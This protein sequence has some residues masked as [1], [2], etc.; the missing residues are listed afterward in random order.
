MVSTKTTAKA[1]GSTDSR[2][3]ASAPSTSRLSNAIMGGRSPSNDER[4][5]TNMRASESHGTLAV[6]VKLIS[7]RKCWRLY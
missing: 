3:V 5:F 4:Q 7:L 6:R 1:D 2:T